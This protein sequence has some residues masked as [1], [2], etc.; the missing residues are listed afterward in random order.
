MIFTKLPEPQIGKGVTKENRLEEG[1]LNT[2]EIECL[3]FDICGRIGIK[4]CDTRY[5][6]RVSV[7]KIDILKKVPKLRLI[8]E[9]RDIY[10]Y[11]TRSD[12]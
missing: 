10:I 5:P 4:Q 8:D 3:N 7:K 12:P 2:L 9:Y 6:L 1:I 11:I